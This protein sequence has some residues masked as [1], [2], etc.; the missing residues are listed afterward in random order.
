MVFNATF[1]DISAISWR[2]ITLI[3]QVCE[4]DAM[5][6]RLELCIFKDALDIWRKKCFQ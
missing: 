4:K 1:N 5:H 2:A 3:V 6:K